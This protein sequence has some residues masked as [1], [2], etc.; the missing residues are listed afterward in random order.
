MARRK[1]EKQEEEQ[2]NL[3][4]DWYVPDDVPTQ[5]VT[6]TV[7]QRSGEEFVISFFEQR[8][9]IILDEYDRQKAMKLESAKA[10]CVARIYLTPERL[11]HFI[12]VFKQQLDDYSEPK[13]KARDKKPAKGKSSPLT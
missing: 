12:A 6:N 7:I 3:R 2:I 4:L 10:L 8:G 5:R 13:K 11:E 1:T 9:P